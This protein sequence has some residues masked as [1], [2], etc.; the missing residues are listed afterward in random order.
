MDAEKK[1]R[2]EDL[3]IK[4]KVW[5]GHPVVESGLVNTLLFQDA[6]AASA[7]EYKSLLEISGITAMSSLFSSGCGKNNELENAV[8]MSVKAQGFYTRFRNR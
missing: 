1:K 8:G 4:G 5:Y 6:E 3:K 7:K 2:S